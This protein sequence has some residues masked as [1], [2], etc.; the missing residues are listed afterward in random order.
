MTYLPIAC[1][2]LEGERQR[3]R[4]EVLERVFSRVQETRP[5]EDG[6]ALRFIAD[7]A[8]LADLLQLIQLERQCCPFLKFR[9][10]VEPGGGPVWLE[11]TGS[12]GA[13]SFLESAMGLGSSARGRP[14][15]IR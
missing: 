2:L 7:E 15:D 4:S 8:E 10:T 1:T 9:L 12:P 11:M 3:R 5:L 6:Y 13:K 14:S